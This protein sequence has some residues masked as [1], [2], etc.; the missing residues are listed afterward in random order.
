VIYINILNILSKFSVLAVI[1]LVILNLIIELNLNLLWAL[2]LPFSIIF[3]NWGFESLKEKQ[4][5]ILSVLLLL[6]SLLFI[7]NFV[8]LISL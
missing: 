5:S 4:G 2:S 6:T 1:I 7:F 3:L 8:N